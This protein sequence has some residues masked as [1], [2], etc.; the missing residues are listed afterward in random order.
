MAQWRER[1]AWNPSQRTVGI[2][3][4]RKDQR[5]VL[6][7]LARVATPVRLVLVGVPPVGPLADEARQVRPP[8]AAV[9]LPFTPDVRALYELLDLVLLP[10]RGE[11]LSQGL[12]EAMALAK[13]VIASAA[14]G[15]LDLIATDVD[16]LLVPP[17]ES[18]AWALA[19]D[20]LL[21]DPDDARRL[22]AAARRTARETFALDRTIAR[23]LELYHRVLGGSLAPAP[24]SG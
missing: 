3:A 8:H 2:V 17:L 5:V 22:G 24:R 20:H 7:A 13:P 6:A 11:G 16:G 15:N 1:I 4:R 10:S 21:T 23:T 9:C 12:L 19:I 18:A 14:G